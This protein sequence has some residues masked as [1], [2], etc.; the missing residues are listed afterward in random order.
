M[1]TYEGNAG[2]DVSVN[3]LLHFL[4]ALPVSPA[5]L[6]AERVE[7]RHVRPTYHLELNY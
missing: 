3:H 6:V 1:S 2:C 7:G 5:E 4:R